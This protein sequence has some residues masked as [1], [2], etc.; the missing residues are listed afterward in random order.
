MMAPCA[1]GFG[2]SADARSRLQETDSW[3][4][5][6]APRA[7]SMR[8]SH[9]RC[10]AAPARAGA[11]RHAHGKC[12]IR[13]DDLGG[14]AVHIAD[15]IGGLATAQ[16]ILVSAIVKDLVAGSGVEFEDRG[17]A[18]AQRSSRL[19]A[20]IRREVSAKHH[21][22]S[23]DAV[24]VELTSCRVRLI[25]LAQRQPAPGRAQSDSGCTFNAALCKRVVSTR[26]RQGT[27]GEM[28]GPDE[29]FR[30]RVY[31]RLEQMRSSETR[32]RQIDSQVEEQLKV[33]WRRYFARPG[34][35]FN[36][37]TLLQPPNYL[38]RPQMN[39]SGRP[40]RGQALRHMPRRGSTR[41]RVHTLVG[42][43]G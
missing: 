23:S 16:E 29:R 14:L 18:R 25:R 37:A 41:P 8:K 4:H 34:K 21:S 35:T 1:S 38:K 6:T 32:V 42:L 33:S 10:H 17:E 27:G 20:A 15:R 43:Q 7:Q 40:K 26:N 30:G 11:P 31:G 36:P 2:V 28:N 5:S 3:R 13:G 9:R 22:A 12:E 24:F 39:C 19:V